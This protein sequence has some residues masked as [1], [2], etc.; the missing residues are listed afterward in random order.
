MAS[1]HTKA[2]REEYAKLLHKVT[3]A[4]VDR[5]LSKVARSV[6]LHE[7]TVRHIASGKNKNPTLETLENLADYL[8]GVK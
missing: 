1:R 7:N 5:N 6:G 8:F 2:L 3:E 4:L